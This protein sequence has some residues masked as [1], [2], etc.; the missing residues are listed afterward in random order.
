V[1]HLAPEVAY[2]RQHGREV[3]HLEGYAG[4]AGPRPA[5]VVGV[6]GKLHPTRA[7]QYPCGMGFSSILS[8]RLQPEGTLIEL[9]LAIEVADEEDD[10]L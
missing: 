2:P 6:D 3:V 9:P 8:D 10:A 5:L 7:V 4:W 1:S